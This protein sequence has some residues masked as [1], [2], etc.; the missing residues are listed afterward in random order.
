MTVLQQ[1]VYWILRKLTI[2][3]LMIS[4]RY[5]HISPC[6]HT[7]TFLIKSDVMAIGTP[8]SI[9][10]DDRI[11]ASTCTASALILFEA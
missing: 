6:L 11:F 3:V 10:F 1:K 5:L 2:Y 4:L 9:P 8:D 7:T